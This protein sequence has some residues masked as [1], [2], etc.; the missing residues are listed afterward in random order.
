MKLLARGAFADKRDLDGYYP[1]ELAVRNGH[2]K[3]ANEL[4]PLKGSVFLSSTKASEL[5]SCYSSPGEHLEIS[6]DSS[7]VI[8]E[9][10]QTDFKN[11]NYPL[12]LKE[13]MMSEGEEDFLVNDINAKRILM[14][15][16]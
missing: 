11:R 3:V 5:K 7:P 8:R 10:S 13:D 6:F 16:G 2:Q 15:L 14:L 9:I 12:G 4:L 1:F